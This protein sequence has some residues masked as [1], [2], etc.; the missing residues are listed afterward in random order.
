[1][2]RGLAP[3]HARMPSKTQLYFLLL[4]RVLDG[5]LGIGAEEVDHSFFRH[6]VFVRSVDN[7]PLTVIVLMIRSAASFLAGHVTSL[8]VG[9]LK[10]FSAA[11]FSSRGTTHER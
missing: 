1:M 6:M 3:S 4:V 10:I 8:G 11:V 7:R 5:W 9:L 2:H